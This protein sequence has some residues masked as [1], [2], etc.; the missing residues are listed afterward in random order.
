MKKALIYSFVKQDLVDRYSGSLLGGAWSFIMPLVNIMIFVL[1]FSK[2][3]GARLEVLGGEFSEYSYSIYLV[4]GILA[5][6]AFANTISRVTN[7][8]NEKA[9]LIGKVNMSLAWLPVFVLITET[10]VFSL[11]YFFFLIFMLL[12]DFP[13]SPYLLLIPF[14]YVIQ[15]L[16]AYAIGFIC[17]VLGVFI[18]DI[19]ELVGV[20]L[21]LMFWLTP[22]VYVI[23]ILPEGIQ[24]WF[25][26]NPVY[27]LI[28]AYRDLL[29]Y[30][31][32]PDPGALVAICLFGAVLL[33][34]GIFL[35]RKLE[36]DIRD[37]I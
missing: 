35:L 23:N 36:R 33:A 19:K 13:L 15:Q 37:F 27:H 1:V 4:T 18:R 30:Q 12:I 5:W 14:V 25:K 24:G 21:Q 2:I 26:L 22:I 11:S 31:R 16:L 3:M 7:V 10:I 17:A 28:E 29:M 9:S 8:F 34:C 32:L 20:V 6:T